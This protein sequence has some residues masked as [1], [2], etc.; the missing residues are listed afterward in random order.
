MTGQHVATHCKQIFSEYGW[1]ETLIS[2]NGPCYAVEAFTNMMK[3]YSVNHITMSP[4][5]PQSNRLAEKFAQIVKNLFHRA[6]EEGKDTFKCLMIYCNTSL[7]SSLQS[8]M[9]ILWSRS[10]GSDLPMF[11][12]A[13]KQLGFD[14][15]QLRIKYKNKHLPLHDLHLGQDVIFQDSASKWWFPATITNLC[16]ESRSYKITTK[17]CVTCRK[18]QAHLKPYSQQNKKS[19]DKH[20]LSQSSNMWT[21]KSNCKQCN[22]S[23]NQTQSYS[24]P[25]RD[26]KPLDKLDL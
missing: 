17:E 3:E 26:I 18:T 7:S 11:N 12:A 4:H 23:G 21:I 2:D 19:E 15:E 25:K 5:Y 20:C 24:R 1:P 13:K 6:T 14:S 16:S 10:A 22:T 8:P 9:Q